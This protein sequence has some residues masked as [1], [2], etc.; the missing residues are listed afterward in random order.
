MGTLVHSGTGLGCCGRQDGGS[1]P[2]LLSQGGCWAVGKPL[3]TALGV[4][5]HSL[6]H[7]T[8]RAGLGSLDTQAPRMPDTVEELRMEWGPEGWI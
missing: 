7:R 5:K 6:R 3:G 1:Q 8:A 2:R 4:G